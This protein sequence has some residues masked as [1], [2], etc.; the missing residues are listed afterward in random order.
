MFVL[1]GA[2]VLNTS[3][4]QQKTV[5]PP[6]NESPSGRT[7]GD[8][9]PTPIADDVLTECSGF[10]AGSFSGKAKTFYNVGGSYDAN[11][12][13]IRLSQLPSELSSSDGAYFDFYGC[14]VSNGGSAAYIDPTPLTFDLVYR[15]SGATLG[16]YG[17]SKFDADVFAAIQSSNG[18]SNNRSDY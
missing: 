15:S 12:I 11:R 13:R 9:N 18:T 3:C 10:T 14:E 6:I 2:F 5:A 8:V 17:S 7:G 16:T 1:W 4:Q